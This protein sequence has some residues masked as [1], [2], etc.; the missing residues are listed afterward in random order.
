MVQK[1]RVFQTLANALMII[2]AICA[3]A[4]FFLML[5]SSLTDEQTLLANGYSF[6]PEK[7]ST[8]AYKYLFVQSGSVAR[9]YV[10]S[11]SVTVVGTLSNLFVTLL[12][13]YPLSRKE[14][15]G[16]QIFAF[17][18]F[19][20]MLFSGGLVPAYL[21][22]T[23]T[24]HIRNTVI[25]LLVPGLLMSPFNVI[26]MRTYFTTNIPDEVIDAA[27]VDGAGEFG[28]LFKVVFPMAL[29]I[30]ATIGLLVGL[31][32]W[33]DWMNGLYY[34][35]DDKLYSIQVLLMKI[36]R[37]L[38]QLRQQ[39][40]NGSGNVNMADLPSTSVRMALTVMGILPIMIIYPFL[41]RYFVKG[42]TIGAV[43]G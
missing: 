6:F 5:M 18:L 40:Q 20:T 39:A 28:I 26:M 30:T 21:M 7:F 38:D 11:I 4:P 32:Y 34:I 31:A 9:G 42:I 15:P 33:N 1:D 41:Q 13:A 22:W 17:Y 24:F 35:N 43:K 16:R 25:A 2:L 37:N 27:R 29:P 14:L 8:Y 10:I 19:F 36:Q 23:Q 3:L 12:Y